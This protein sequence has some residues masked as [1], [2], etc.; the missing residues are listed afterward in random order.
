[1][2]ER[3][4]NLRSNMMKPTI[5][6]VAKKAGVSIST[7]S[8]VLNGS[9]YASEKTRKKV[10]D[11]AKA[12]SFNANYFARGLKGKNPGIIGLINKDYLH[13]FFSILSD[14]IEE[15]ARNNNLGV[16]SVC[17][18][19]DK[20]KERACIDMLHD[21]N[22]RQVIFATA[23]DVENIMYAKKLGMH[24]ILIERDLGYTQVDR[25]LYNNVASGALVASVFHE[26]K[27]QRVG[28]IGMDTSIGSIENDRYEGFKNAI[29]EYGMLMKSEWDIHIC[30]DYTPEYGYSA[31]KQILHDVNGPIPEAILVGSD[32]LLVGV[33]DYLHE[34]EI[35][36]PKDIS[37]VSADNFY[38]EIL[39]PRI[40]SIDYSLGDLGKEAIGLILNDE[41]GKKGK[42]NQSMDVYNTMVINPTYVRRQSLIRR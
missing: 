1:M 38:T 8:R 7:T 27:F 18:K 17:S 39:I 36:V 30:K 13:P 32:Y 19:G 28:F 31:C 42:S 20:E 34:K 15:E 12:I 26:C 40:D 22:V 5:K 14:G 37:I 9:G 33:M 24:C 16:I 11:V 35:K 6:D 25:V 29:T 4:H 2:W 23:T 21:R 3:F 10:E 41:E